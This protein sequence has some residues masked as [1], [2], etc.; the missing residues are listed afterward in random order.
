MTPNSVIFLISV[1][2]FFFLK[3]QKE[4][5]RFSKSQGYGAATNQHSSRKI[6]RGQTPIPAHR[7]GRKCLCHLRGSR[8]RW[9]R[10]S[11]EADG[12]GRCFISMCVYLN[13]GKILCLLN[14][15]SSPGVSPLG[16]GGTFLQWLA[17]GVS[18]LG[19]NLLGR[20]SGTAMSPGVPG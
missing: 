20:G 12:V 2:Q 7:N 11:A 19:G 10:F 5:T 17:W 14:N 4:L 16:L 18:G 13:R 9:N 15:D 3:S 6:F 1:F 8:L